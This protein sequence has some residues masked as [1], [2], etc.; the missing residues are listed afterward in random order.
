MKSLLYHCGCNALN[1]KTFSIF[2]MDINVMML[3]KEFNLTTK[4]RI[5]NLK[6]SLLLFSSVHPS[7]ESTCMQKNNNAF[8]LSL[9]LTTVTASLRRDSPNTRMC[10]SS[11]MWISSNTA[12]TATG[13]TAEMIEPN[14]RQDNRSTLPNRAASI[15]HM[16]YIIPPTKKAFHRVPTTANIKMVP[17]FS[18]K[19]RM[20]RK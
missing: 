20:G 14:S 17:R 6:Y 4:M 9:R 12:R 7:Q 8:R 15:W 19:A 18:V 3:T 2:S 5:S 10:S 11:L 16:P 13:S 1:I